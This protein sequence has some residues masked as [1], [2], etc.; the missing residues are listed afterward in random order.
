MAEFAAELVARND[1]ISDLTERASAYLKN[2]AVDARAV[3]H[4]ALVLDELLTNVAMHGGAGGAHAAVRLAIEADRV[5]AEVLDKGIMFDPRPP[6]DVN[7]SG[8]VEDRE[9][10]G[11]GLLLVQ[12]LTDNL[13][14]ERVGDLNRTTFSVPRARSDQTD[15]N[16]L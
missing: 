1:A 3:H 9:I 7:R 12:R 5:A 13:S 11:L 2:A 8:N 16:V 6:R 4:V 14:Y 15:R 10:G